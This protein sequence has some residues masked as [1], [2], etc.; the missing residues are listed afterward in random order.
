MTRPSSYYM[1]FLCAAL[2]VLGAYP[3]NAEN[4][5]GRSP[6]I[7]P[8]VLSGTWYPGTRDEL[9]RVIDQYLSNARGEPVAGELKAIIVPHAGYRFSGGVAAHAYSLLKGSHIDRVILIG[10]SH[11]MLFDGA[12][13]NL[14]SGYKTPLGIVPVDQEF[15]RALISSGR[16]I[17]FIKTAHLME[18]SLE[19]Q[20]PFLQTVLQDF[21]IVPILISKQDFS[22][23]QKLADTIIRTM[24]GRGKT[25]LLASSDLSHFHSSEQ[26]EVLDKR[27][28]AHI[29]NLDPQGLAHDLS[30]GKCEACGHTAVITV[31]VAARQLGVK[32]SEIL[33][34]SHSGK[35]TGDNKR[36]VGYLS[37]ALFKSYYKDPHRN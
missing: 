36:V 6:D 4:K 18:H 34:Y 19:I 16:E 27:F 15:S 32:K 1:F 37:A 20:I 8:S 21:K 10:P 5:S 26:A 23:C 35:V 3:L 12:S 24:K 22:T 28:I 17:R 29:K 7:R 25:L 30:S 9:S 31:L 13:V 11:R 14:Q 2:V 33:C